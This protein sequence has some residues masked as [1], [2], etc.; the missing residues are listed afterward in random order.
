MKNI[1]PLVL[2]LSIGTFILLTGYISG[3]AAAALNHYIGAPGGAGSKCSTCH[4]ASNFGSISAV[5]DIFEAGTTTPATV[6][7]PGTTYDMAVEITHTAGSPNGYGFQCVSLD[8]IAQA[9]AFSS[10]QPGMSI[11]TLAANG[12]EVAEHSSIGGSPTFNFKWT[13]PP[14]S[15][16]IMDVDFFAGGIVANANG[17]P[18]GDAG[19]NTPVNVTLPRG[20]MPIELSDFSGRQSDNSIQLEW[21][22]A[23]E[24]N[25]SHFVIEHANQSLEFNAIAKVD[26]AG[27]TTAT[28]QYR[29][30]H[31]NPQVG[32]NHYYRLK[33]IDFDGSFDYSEIIVV[34]MEGEI[35]QPSVYPIPATHEVTI[36]TAIKN[37]GMYTQ[38]VTDLNGK[39]V[40][41]SEMELSSGEQ[42][43][44]LDI[45]N[46]S[47]GQYIYTIHNDKYRITTPI[48]KF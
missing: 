44:K 24:I 13:A 21:I 48:I 18:A 40:H 16:T 41:R 12:V 42:S 11:V 5:I 8:G 15:S 27:T 10:P 23:S 17:S 37:T 29:Y 3:P 4:T 20:V 46:W 35:D 26:G 32:T 36:K 33:Q 19:S 34:L 2:M 9:G 38:T 45:N 30:L 1:Y 25:N 14:S 22:T 7:I 39:V 6:W 28:Q 47:S 31:T 43:L